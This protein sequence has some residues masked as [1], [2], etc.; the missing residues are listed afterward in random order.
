MQNKFT[1]RSKHLDF[2]ILDLICIEVSY[3]LAYYIRLGR[4]VNSTPGEYTMMNIMVILIHLSIMFISEGYSG[5]LMRNAIQELKKVVIHNAEMFAVILFILFFA[6]Q[7]SVYSRILFALFVVIDTITMYIVRLVRKK[8]LYS[9][10]DK[11]RGKGQMLIVTNHAHAQ[12]LVK[13]LAESGYRNY[14]IHGIVILDKNMTGQKIDGIDVVA[15]AEGMYEYVKS[16]IIDEI[17]LEYDGEGVAEITKRFLAMGVVVH[18]SINNIL[19][20]TPNAAVENISHYTVITTSINIM[21]FKQ[22][23]I[24]RLM[25]IGVSIIGMAITAILFVI[26][27]PIIFIQSPGPIFFKQERVGKNGRRFKI[28]KFRSMYMDAEERKKDLMKKN[29]MQGLMFKMEND[30]RII[31]SEKG[32]GKGIGN[33]IRE[34]SIDELPQF[35]NILKG[36]MSLIGTRPPTVNEYEQYD[37][38]HKIRLSMKPGLTGMWQV[39]G[40][41][42]ITDFEEV[43]RL[44][45]EYI[46]NWSIG[47]DIRILFKTIQVV[48]GKKGSK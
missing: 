13:G 17:F 19:P 7:S 44:D 20:G 12:S 23:V 2:I 26:F 14:L 48:L 32:S 39:S 16:N 8:V 33:F 11:E 22:K 38:H 6:K 25:D 1:S 45:T 30:P 31:G 41:S 27:A 47:M 9:N 15:D 34:T 40:R 42:D 24:K 37:L 5:I 43:V 18:V 28:Y 10:E 35:W 36:D 4:L 46:E 29:E 21:S 3:W